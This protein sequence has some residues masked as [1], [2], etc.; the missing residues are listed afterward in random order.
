MDRTLSRS[1]SMQSVRSEDS[2]HS[3]ISMQSLHDDMDE[4]GEE[5]QLEEPKLELPQL[6][7]L[8][9]LVTAV[10]I[11]LGEAEAVHVPVRTPRYHH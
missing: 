6:E 4:G 2:W 11:L 10:D 7:P 5:G 3:A 9:R 8:P 1:S